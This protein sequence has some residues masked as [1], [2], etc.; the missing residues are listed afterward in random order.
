MHTTCANNGDIRRERRERE[1]KGEG[2]GRRCP[3][4]IEMT[5]RTRDGAFGTRDDDRAKKRDRVG[6]VLWADETYVQL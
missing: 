4:E 1:G 5:N 2:K 3:R 6:V